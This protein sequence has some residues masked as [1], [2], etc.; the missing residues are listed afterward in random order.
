MSKLLMTDLDG[1]IRKCK[2][3]PNGFINDPFDQEIMVEAKLAL[4]FYVNKGYTVVGI[5][6]QGGCAAINPKTG[7]PYKSLEDVVKEQSYTLELC[8]RLAAIIFCVDFAGETRIDVVRP[9][10]LAINP[11]FN[12]HLTHDKLKGT[13]RKPGAGMLLWAMEWLGVDKVDTLYVGDRFED[14]QAAA[15]AGVKFLWNTEW[16]KC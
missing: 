12:H 13:Y 2:S 10:V 11:N 15:N 3:N 14:E 16:Y 4:E 1:T 5:T 7:N 6:N 9:G 8:P